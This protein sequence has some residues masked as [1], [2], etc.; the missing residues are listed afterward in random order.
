MSVDIEKQED[1]L[2]LHNHTLHVLRHNGGALVKPDQVDIARCLNTME[3]GERSLF[4]IGG[5]FHHIQVVSVREVGAVFCV[6]DGVHLHLMLIWILP[7]SIIGSKL[8][9]VYIPLQI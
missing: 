5:T 4:L 6:N 7:F 8:T 9:V 2:D 3:E 1:T